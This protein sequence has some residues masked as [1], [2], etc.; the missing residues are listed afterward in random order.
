MLID[1][2]SPRPTIPGTRVDH[3]VRQAAAAAGIGHVHPTSRGTPW[4]PTASTAA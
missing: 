2:G 3:P 4:P 1:T